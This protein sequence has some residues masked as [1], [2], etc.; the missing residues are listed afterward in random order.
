MKTFCS[1]FKGANILLTDDG[2]VKLGNVIVKKK[3]ERISSNR[4]LFIFQRISVLQR[5]SRRQCVKE[6]R[7]SELHIGKNFD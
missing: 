1:L 7:L 4:Y 2:N 3:K 6:N 5:V